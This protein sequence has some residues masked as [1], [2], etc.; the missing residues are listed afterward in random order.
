MILPAFL[1]RAEDPGDVVCSGGSCEIQ[2]ET[3]DGKPIMNDEPLRRTPEE[4]R[5]K[6][7][8]KPMGLGKIHQTDKTPGN[9]PF[10]SWE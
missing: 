5:T 3:H 7:I 8:S 1:L 2:P 4:E 6:E 9:D 10:D